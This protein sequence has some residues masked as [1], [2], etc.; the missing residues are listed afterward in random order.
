MPSYRLALV[1]EGLKECAAGGHVSCFV[2]MRREVVC[3]GDKD[4]L[5]Q[6]APGEGEG[7]PE[8][9]SFPHA[10]RGG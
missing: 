4:A 6:C 1:A 3:V 7:E 9:S 2:T 5:M 10:V 8:R